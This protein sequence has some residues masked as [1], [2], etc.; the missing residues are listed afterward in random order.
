MTAGTGTWSTPDNLPMAPV[1]STSA[2]LPGV[3]ISDNIIEGN[4]AGTNRSIIEVTGFPAVSFSGN[5]IRNNE[6]WLPNTFISM[7]LIYKL[8]SI[9]SL[10]VPI[11]DVSNCEQRAKSII[12]VRGTNSLT[13]SNELYENNFIIDDY[14]PRITSLS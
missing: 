11:S 2:T 7:S 8:Q 6:N 12:T 13:I 9:K 5:K 3:T 1:A 14:N 10:P 4:F